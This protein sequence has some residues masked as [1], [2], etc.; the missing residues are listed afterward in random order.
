MNLFHLPSLPSNEELC[1]LL[2]PDH[3]IRIERII[4]TGQ[5]S[6]TDFWYD[7][8]CDEWVAL[9]QGQARLTWPD[10][11]TQNLQAG[12]WLFIPAHEQHRVDWTSKEPPCIWLAIHGKLS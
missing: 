12:D 8:E 10:G 7:Q 1:E 4:S 3:G 5:A 2:L 6:P 11:R 9:L